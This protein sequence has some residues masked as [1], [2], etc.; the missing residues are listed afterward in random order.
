MDETIKFHCDSW[1]QEIKKPQKVA[2][3]NRRTE[4][5]HKEGGGPNH[6]TILQGQWKG[7]SNEK[8]TAKR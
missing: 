1:V 8:G 5:R 7:S 3:G 6:Q 4:Q 2:Q